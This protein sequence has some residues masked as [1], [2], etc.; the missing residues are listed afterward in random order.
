MGGRYLEISQEIPE[1]NQ[2]HPKST[3]DDLSAVGWYFGKSRLNR[4][5]QFKATH[6]LKEN[7]KLTH[8][9]RKYNSN[10]LT[11][12]IKPTHRKYHSNTNTQS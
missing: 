10:T 4:Q 9:D 7:I 2:H 8:R 12:N 11:Q 6:T 1:N 5:L 3:K